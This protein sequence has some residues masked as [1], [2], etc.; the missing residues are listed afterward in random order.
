M[1]VLSINSNYSQNE[2]FHGWK[3]GL[4]LPK[5]AEEVDVAGDE[6]GEAMILGH[7]ALQPTVN[8][9]LLFEKTVDEKARLR[10]GR[11]SE[12]HRVAQ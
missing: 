6:I 2:V 10:G 4:H 11:T 7:T 9:E 1:L 8:R 3:S 5:S 12:A